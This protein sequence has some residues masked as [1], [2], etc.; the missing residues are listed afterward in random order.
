MLYLSDQDV[1]NLDLNWNDNTQ[2]I[3]NTIACI[4]ENDFSQPVK[5]YLRY[6]DMKNRIIAMPAFVGGSIN[7]SG[8]KWIASFP[9]NIQQDL[10]RAHCVVVLNDPDTGIPAGILN[11]GTVSAIRTASVSGLVLKKYIQ[12]RKP[13][14]VKVGIIG[15][16][17]I[18]RYHLNMVHAVLGDAIASVR[19]FD[20]KGVDLSAVSAGL[21]DKVLVADSWQ[22]AYEDA[23]VFITCTASKERYINQQPK[24]GSLHLNVSL[25]DYTTDVFPWFSGA[26]I[27]D[28]WKEV[29]RENTDIEAFHKENNLMEHQV[30]RLDDLI[31]TDYFNELGPDQAILFNPMGMASFDI[32]ISSHYLNRA[33]IEKVGVSLQ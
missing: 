6:R 7:M 22:E 12:N 28:D 2:V 9:D 25:R 11:S 29:C 10:P 32:A 14:G 13:A 27:V 30:K 16:G 31:S 17:P 23:D 15:F 8:I 21:Q 4:H 24:A 5:P 18:G 33:L 20:L 19:I 3:E 1:R 26:I